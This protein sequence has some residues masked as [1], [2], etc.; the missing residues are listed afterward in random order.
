MARSKIQPGYDKSSTVSDELGEFPASTG[1]SNEG[2]SKY[3]PRS[4]GS[5]GMDPADPVTGP[6][7]ANPTAPLVPNGAGFP[8]QDDP[9][10]P[11]EGTSGMQNE[12]HDRPQPEK[13]AAKR[14]QS[15]V[16]K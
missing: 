1:P 15:R 6:A 3:Q 11:G 8:V 10:V 12:A 4:A 16:L 14:A 13:A 9:F 5:W 2:L 7:A